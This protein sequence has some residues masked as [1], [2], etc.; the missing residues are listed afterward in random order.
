MAQSTISLI[1]MA[2][3]IVCYAIPKIPLAITTICAAIA[4]GLFGII[5]FTTAFSGF[6]NNSTLLI[7]GMM[8][9]GQACFTSGLADTAGRVLYRFVGTNERVFMNLLIVIVALLAVF[10]NGAMLVAVMMP[11]ID[12]I[13]VQSHGSITRKHTYFPLGVAS[14]LGNNL[15][16][17]GATST[18]TAAGLMAAAGYGEMPIFAPTLINLPP[19]IGIIVIYILFGYQYQK[20]CFDF[21]EIPVILETGTKPEKEGNKTWKMV[22]VGGTM[23]CV[24]AAMIAGFNYA[25]SALIGAAILILTNCIDEKTAY[26]SINW[27]T[28]IIIAGAIGFSAGLE[29]SGAGQIMADF[30]LRICGPVGKS[31][32]GVCVILFI[33]ASIMSNL[34]SDNATIA[35]LVPIALALAQTL[36]CSD[37]LPFVLATASGTKVAIATPV[38]VATMTMVQVA[39]YRFKDYIRVGGVLNLLALVGTAIMIKLVY[40]I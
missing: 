36:G 29:K 10:L 34:M 3:A 22:V 35:V 37:V 8:I 38:S 16:T 7:V 4:M 23:I 25:A 21:P 28:V 15:T 5:P 24:I 26:K 11:I 14:T 2:V 30:I 31:P 1:I 39:G 18:M 20:K 27:S 32:L 17:I 12:I 9:I 33:I 13:V 19:L 40:F 6:A